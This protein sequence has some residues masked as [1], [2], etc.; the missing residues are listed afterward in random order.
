[1]GIKCSIHYPM[2]KGKRTSMWD[3]IP[4][5]LTAPTRL[6]RYCCDVLKENSTPN[7]MIATGVRWDESSSRAKKRGIFERQV[8]N[9]NKAIKTHSDAD[10][11]A[12]LYAPCKLKAKR[13][14]NPIVDWR[15]TD[16]WDFLHDAKIPINPLYEC[17]Q[18]RV[19]CIGC[20]MAGKKR[21]AQFRKWPA[22]EKLYIMAFDR[23]VA[24]RNAKGLQSQQ[25]TGQEVFSWWME[26][27]VLPGQMTLDEV[28]L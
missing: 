28:V 9:K 1:M 8:S 27:N 7:R 16:V 12:E 25:K 19:G 14:V 13:I 5:K 2:Y 17:G 4:Q 26:E 24:T 20:P 23:M 10:N 22:Y 18:K 3:L 21:Y 6:M 11:L 15:T